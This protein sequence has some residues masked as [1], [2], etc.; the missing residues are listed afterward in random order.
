LNSS[1][2]ARF[3][4]KPIAVGAGVPGPVNVA[5]HDSSLSGISVPVARTGP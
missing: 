4:K 3:F 1:A 5:R 2:I